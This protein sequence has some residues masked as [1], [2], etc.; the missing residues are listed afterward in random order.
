MRIVFAAM[1]ALLGLQSLPGWAE[2]MSVPVKDTSF[3]DE[4]GNR[5]QQVEITVAA[6]VTKVWAAFVTDAGFESW[7]APVAH[8]TLANDGMMESS[9]L[10]S[11]KIGDP[12]NIRNRIVAYL[13][14]RLLVLHNEHAPLHGPFKQDVIDK[15]RTVIQFED[16]GEG[17]T[18][19]IESGVGY[20]QGPD[21]D[22][23]Y[24]HFGTGNAEEL[25]SL[26][27]RFATG[28]VDWKAEAAKMQASVGNS[29]P[30]N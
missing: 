1:A 22:S 13:P 29:T 28:P 23:M 17:R 14:E 8:I 2:P 16:A 21:F 5:V 9:Y 20:G 27:Q 4:N 12:D 10:L 19:I 25:E 11:S 7:A 18:R 3:R 26:A 15:I 30:K 6:P 24:A